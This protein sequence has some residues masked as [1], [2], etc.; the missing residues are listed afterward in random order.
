LSEQT[1]QD[2]AE[3]ACKLADEPEIESCGE[4]EAI[5]RNED[6]DRNQEADQE[7]ARGPG[8]FKG[9]AEHF[10]VR[11]KETT[12]V[13]GE[14]ETIDAEGDRQE[15]DATEHQTPIIAVPSEKPDGARYLDEKGWGGPGRWHR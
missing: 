11:P 10:G 6:C 14:P 9:L 12:L 7:L 15:D 3:D 8:I 13:G 1:Q 4:D 5:D 2:K